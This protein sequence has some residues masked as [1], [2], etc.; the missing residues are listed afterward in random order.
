MPSSERRLPHLYTIGQPL[1]ITFRLHDSLPPGRAFMP[2]SITSGEAFVH[3]DRLLDSGR[4]GPLFLR[5]PEIAVRIVDAIHRGAGTDYQLHTWVVMPNHVHLLMTPNSDVSRIMQRIK[6][7]SAMECNR[8]MDRAGRPFWQ[9]ESYDHMVR[10]P[11]EF[12][13]IARYIEQNP[14]KAGLT[15]SPERW[16]WSSAKSR[17][18][19]RAN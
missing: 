16:P 5:R 9:R 3:M 17:L 15:D 2:S 8:V 18:K 19:S 7:A 11:E 13:R 1:F 6:G 12:E 14:V 10:G 4:S